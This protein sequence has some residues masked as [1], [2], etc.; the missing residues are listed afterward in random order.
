[1][2][3]AGGV[4][5]RLP[6]S[7]QRSQSLHLPSPAQDIKIDIPSEA[8]I[9]LQ[10][11]STFQMNKVQA[12]ED[13]DTTKTKD[14]LNSLTTSK[15]AFV[16]FHYLG[17]RDQAVK[18]FQDRG[19]MEF[20]GS[21][22]TL[23]IEEIEPEGILWNGFGLG[24]KR[25][26]KRFCNA[27]IA[28]GI[29]LGCWFTF[30]YLP[31][32]SYI[33][34]FDYETTGKPSGTVYLGFVCLVGAANLSMYLTCAVSMMFVGFTRVSD[35]ETGYL[36]TYMAAVCINIS[37]DMVVLYYQ[38]YLMLTA[39]GATTAAGKPLIEMES[40]AA[41]FESHPMQQTLGSLL[42]LYCFPGTFLLPFMG[43]GFAAIFVVWRIMQLV[44]RSRPDLV[45]RGAE[46]SMAIFLPMDFG[47][48][49]DLTINFILVAMMFFLPMGFYFPILAV[50]I[51]SHIYVYAYDH[52]RILRCTQGF[53][54]GS[55]RAERTAEYLIAIPTGIILSC[56][57]YKNNCT[58]TTC[59]GEIP[60]VLLCIG[61]FLSH[62]VA[63]CA[64]ICYVVP[65]FAVADKEVN[66]EAYESCAKRQACSWFTANPI[67]C[68]R[69][70][71]FYKHDPPCS[72]FLRGR[73]HMMERNEDI[74]QYFQMFTAK[75]TE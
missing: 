11:K 14:L 39:A 51:I 12:Q 58:E 74:N 50:L 67:H 16:V 59:I 32:A 31:Y 1:V 33:A 6:I 18:K 75:E 24:R 34:M 26:N 7:R 37:C 40:V 53:V 2:Q 42:F 5:E 52:G 57:V 66:E 9:R 38:S 54:L 23:R 29:A 63:H 27:C 69:S 15:Y 35:R 28:I 61:A 73:E 17:D 10:K 62:V 72:F 45:G 36:V 44:T 3:D 8:A 20:R 55:F 68:L 49:A 71:D 22:V 48:Y 30:I 19:G 64:I 21:P 43:E 41:T 60:L 13:E 47:R 4:D 56:L 25:R 46:R 70:K 65:V